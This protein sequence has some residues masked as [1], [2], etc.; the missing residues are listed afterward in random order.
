MLI[1]NLNS[2]FGQT[3]TL[4]LER[5]EHTTP[6]DTKEKLC[7]PKVSGG[8]F[9]TDITALS[10]RWADLPTG[11]CIETT[12]QEMLTICPR[13][14]PRIEAYNGLVG[15]LKDHYGT[16]LTIKSRKTK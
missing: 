6:V 3:P 5:Q 7:A 16:T 2:L 10:S 4:T 12:L 15:Y 9:D 14:R 13:H 11:I 8:K 1:T